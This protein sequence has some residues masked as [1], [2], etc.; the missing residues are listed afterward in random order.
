M[1]RH[2]SK[3][4]L[5]L[6]VFTLLCLAGPVMAKDVPFKGTVS[7]GFTSTPP[8]ACNSTVTISAGGQATYLGSESRSETVYALAIAPTTGD[9]Y[10]AGEA[11]AGDTPFYGISDAVV[12]RLS[13]TLTSLNR[14][15]YAAGNSGRSQAKAI[16]IHPATG[17]VYVAGLAFVTKLSKGA[18]FA[19]LASDLTPIF[20]AAYNNGDIYLY[21]Y[22][23][24]LALAISPS[25]GDVYVTG[26][27]NVTNFPGTTG[28]A[29]PAT[30]GGPDAF[31]IRLS[32]E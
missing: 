3:A 13:S 12:A 7:G 29:Q 30:G 28:G 22:D 31:V 23:E 24:A 1:N 26:V 4:G 18:F 9:V 6:A 19:R 20:Q 14:W 25:T 17:D 16:A 10:V 32:F 21:P 2:M 27:I 11:I 8:V 15:A 5:L